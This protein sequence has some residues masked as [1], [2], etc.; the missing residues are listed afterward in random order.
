VI[1]EDLHWI[2]SETQA[3]LDHLVESLGS[4]RL[5]LVVNYRPEYQHAWGGKTFYGQMRLDAL[6]AESATDLLDAL[7]GDDP[8]LASLKQMLIRRGNPFFLEETIRTMV[9]TRILTGERGHYH[10]AQEIRTIQVPTTVQAILAARIDRLAPEDKRL[11]QVA[12]VIGKDVPLA[13]LQAIAGLPEDGLRRGLDRLQTAEFVYETGLFPELEYSFKHALTHDVAYGGLL[14]DRRR[15]LHAR[16]VEA[17]EKLH[18]DHLDEEIERLAHHALR[19]ELGERTVPYLRQAGA[20]ASARSVPSEA[21]VW[22]EQALSVLASLRETQSTL[23]QTFDI[24]VELRPV[25]VSLGEVSA[26]IESL[27]LAEAIARKLGD[28]RRLGQAYALLTSSHAAVADLDEAILVGARALAIAERID[29]LKLR[30]LT[31]SYLVE[32]YHYR[33]EFDR[34]VDLAKQNIAVLPR[35]WISERVGTATV[36]SVH[37]RWWLTMS[38]TQLGR[39]TVAKECADEAIRL[40][41]SAHHPN[42]LLGA[43]TAAIYLH[44]R[45][46]DWARARPFCEESISVCLAGGFNEGPARGQ[47][48]WALAELG[49]SSAALEQLLEAERQIAHLA[50]RGFRQ[51]GGRYVELGRASLALGR[52]DDAE[53]L[54]GRGLELDRSPGHTAIVWHLL[55]DVA[56]HRERFNPS[57]AEERYCTALALGEPCGMR[58]LTAHCHRGLGELY[59]RTGKRQQAHEH[60]STALT[61]Y[62]DMGMTYWLEK[63]EAEIQG[64]SSDR[65]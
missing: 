19:G 1:F 36:T 5:L 59:A 29:D 40:A 34:V 54:G 55:A 63:V 64:A 53:R 2:D 33:S 16:I 45:N 41:Q 18:R 9:E 47:L 48:A 62:R 51:L 38:L 4:A 37:N 17:I 30:I 25:L 6:S 42:T 11:L 43:Y 57:R 20:K 35:E 46:G 23:E 50:A 14:Q 65:S 27:H 61:L 13:L 26:L 49:E 31:T 44:L 24:R 52:L 7:L 3:F 56:N 28:E 32:T 10:A 12:S 22:L 21:R 58:P 60:L 8:G 15:A 39:F